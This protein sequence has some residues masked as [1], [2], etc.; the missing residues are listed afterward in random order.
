M[1]RPSAPIGP[2]QPLQTLQPMTM[3]P[4]AVDRPQQQ[5]GQ[6]QLMAG[7]QSFLSFFMSNFQQKDVRHQ[8]P[9]QV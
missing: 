1:T 9:M 3:G 5:M 8:I 2:V 6:Q 7:Q 4:M